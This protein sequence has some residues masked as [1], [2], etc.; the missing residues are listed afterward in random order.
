MKQLTEYTKNGYQFSLI[1]R[2]GDFAIFAQYRTDLSKAQNYEVIRI[3]QVPECVL[4]GVTVP[5]HEAGPSN[6][7]WGIKGWTVTSLEKAKELM[8]EKYEQHKF[9]RELYFE[10]TSGKEEVL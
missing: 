3:K 1:E 9:H 8:N 7:D 6:E 2:K 4:F 10:R 5:E